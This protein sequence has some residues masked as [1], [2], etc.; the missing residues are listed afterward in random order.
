M[1]G[2]ARLLRGLAVLHVTFVLPQSWKL[3]EEFGPK[4]VDVRP[5]GSLVGHIAAIEVYLADV[6]PSLLG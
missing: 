4:A 5:L 6:L 1:G 2:L 3:C